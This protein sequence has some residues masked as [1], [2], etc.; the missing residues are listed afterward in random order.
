MIY[1]RL[2]PILRLT[3][4]VFLGVLV[5]LALNAEPLSAW[6][7]AKAPRLRIAA[8]PYP[9]FLLRILPTDVNFGEHLYRVRISTLGMGPSSELSRGHFYTLRAGFLDL[10]HIRR[11]IDLTAYVHYRITEC[12]TNKGSGFSFAGVEDTVYR[13]R[14]TYP[15]FWDGL[16]KG[17]RDRIISKIAFDAAER[18]SFDLSNWREIITWYEFHNVP[19]MPE[20]G[21]AFSYED[22]PSHC[23]GTAVALRALRTRG[24]PYNEAVTKELHREIADLRIVSSEVYLKAMDLVKDRWW[25]HKTC[26]K[27]NIDTGLDDGY[28]EPW[29]VRG[30][31]QGPASRPKM[32]RVSGNDFSDVDGYDCSGMVAFEYEPHLLKK[33][34]VLKLLGR[35]VKSVDPVR[36]YPL[37]IRQVRKEIIEEFGADATVP[38]P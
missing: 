22:V 9:N 31:E 27:R 26:L 2:S 1:R 6:Q 18:A 37:I 23:V 8:S 33:D 30:L 16:E 36:D 3:P 14:L 4:I 32:F 15:D 38:Y 5:P 21:S 34:R 25:G 28:V 20:K 24:V 17:E 10:A 19:G 7:A 29:L 11:S 12:L 35:D 13:C